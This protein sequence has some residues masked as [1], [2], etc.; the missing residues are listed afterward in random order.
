MGSTDGRVRV[1]HLQ[2]MAVY[3]GPRRN[4][5]YHIMVCPPPR[6]YHLFAVPL[7]G[8]SEVATGEELREPGQVVKQRPAIRRVRNTCRMRE[9]H[10]PMHVSPTPLRAT[11]LA[12]LL[13]PRNF[14]DWEVASVKLYQT[15]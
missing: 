3:A 2:S 9:V 11:R 5:R 4:I 7:I 6:P 1:F 8:H 10:L 15:S 14:L 13:P 12:D